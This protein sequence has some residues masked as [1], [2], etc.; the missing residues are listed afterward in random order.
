M[1]PARQ[2]FASI[3]ELSQS[4]IPA[5]EQASK[6]TTLY[7][8]AKVEAMTLR[9]GEGRAVTA[10]AVLVT[11]TSQ[12]RDNPDRSDTERDAVQWG[13]PSASGVHLT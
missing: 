3:V 9:T 1:R 7:L 2:G 4:P 5:R 8:G 10:I 11:R 13:H 12:I 6:A